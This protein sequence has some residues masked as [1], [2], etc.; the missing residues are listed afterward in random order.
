MHIPF[1]SVQVNTF[2]PYSETVTVA[3]GL[4]ALGT[5]VAVPVPAV[6]VHVPTPALGTAFSGNDRPQASPAVPAL[7][8]GS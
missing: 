6:I 8:T 3:V 1:T 4:F 5:N 7:A 2:A